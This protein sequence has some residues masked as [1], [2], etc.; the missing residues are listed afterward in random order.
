MSSLQ[1]R[2]DT[3]A[4]K[5]L[6]V[7]TKAIVKR[8]QAQTSCDKARA[9]SVLKEYKRLLTLKAL[10]ADT[11]DTQ[12][13]AP[14]PVRD[15]WRCHLIDTAA[16]AEHC[17]ALAGSLLHHRPDF[18]VTTAEGD[19][20]AHRTLEAYRK[21]FG[22][23]P[24]ALWN[25]GADLGP[26]PANLSIDAGAGA[27]YRSMAAAAT[28]GTPF[29]VTVHAPGQ[30]DRSLGGLRAGETVAQ[31][32]AKYVEASGAQNFV[33]GRAAV[34]PTVRLRAGGDW[35]ADAQ[36]L[37]DAGLQEGGAVFVAVA[38]ERQH[39]DQIPVTVKEVSGGKAAAIYVHP[40][41]GVGRMSTAIQ[42]ALGAPAEAVQLVFQGQVLGHSATAASVGL[43][44]DDIVQLVVGKRRTQQEQS[45]GGTWRRKAL[46]L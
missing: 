41:D 25:W 30:R 45:P 37:G 3:I 28:T 42:D 1:E 27:G 32:F 17:S 7:P 44:A 15:F 18:D 2:R 34:P 33:D 36:L 38:A 14:P 19:A 29:S 43:S 8:Y 20:R 35:L 46:P 39:A 22:E 5:L 31:L 10:H 11:A 9:A 40:H 23:A 24:P 13:A 4:S 26:P 16:Y 6:Q 12:V 21:A